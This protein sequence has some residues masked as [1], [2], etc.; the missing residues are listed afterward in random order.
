MKLKDEPA[1]PDARAA[2]VAL[3]LLSL[4]AVVS[5]FDRVIVNLV[6]GPIKADF[7]LSDTGFAALQGIGF[8]LSYALLPIPIGRLADRYQ[9][10][11]VIGIGIAVFSL[12]TLFT[13]LTRSFWQ[14]LVARCGVGVGEASLT[15][16]AYS[17]LGDYFPQ[18]RLGLAS[19]V[20]VMSA[21]FGTG[22]A[23]ITGGMLIGWLDEIYASSPTAF[24]GLKAWNIA[25]VLAAVPG[26]LIAPLFL[27]L[28]EP[29]RR[30]FAHNAIQQAGHLH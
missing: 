9:R 12:F 26:L 7:H 22:I 3:G 4:A 24:Y 5:L 29:M 13:G 18:E 15:P 8:G 6:V 20:Y 14:L 27:L 19:S 10:R 25:F 30:G 11:W 17:I 21:L 1:W 16:A 28:K 23:Y 2:W